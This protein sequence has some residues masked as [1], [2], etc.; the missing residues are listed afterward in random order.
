MAGA[1]DIVR[2]AVH[3]DDM[4]LIEERIQN[5]EIRP[6]NH[7]EQS[8]TAKI[9]RITPRGDFELPSP[10]LGIE[11]GGQIVTQLGEN[12]KQQ[13]L[14]RFFDVDLSI[15]HHQSNDERLIFGQRVYVRFDLGHAPFAWQLILR[16][17]QLFLKELHV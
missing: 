6:V 9:I 10:A 12:G 8:H 7:I 3:Q 16:L 13:A 15:L 14:K 17:K 5:I 4:K 1:S 2:V 11:G